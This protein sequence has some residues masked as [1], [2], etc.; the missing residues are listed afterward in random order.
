MMLTAG[1]GGMRWGAC[2][3]YGL[4]ISSSG[5]RCRMF[6]KKE[7]HTLKFLH[8]YGTISHTISNETCLQWIHL[9]FPLLSTEEDRFVVMSLS[10]FAFRKWHH[11]L[12]TLCFL[13][14]CVTTLSL[15]PSFFFCC[16]WLDWRACLAH[17]KPWPDLKAKQSVELSARVA[18]SPSRSD[19]YTAAHL[20]SWTAAG[21]PADV[22][23]E[24]ETY[25]AFSSCVCKVSEM[26]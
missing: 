15:N 11:F 2:G 17:T 13:Q 23:W 25:Y 21:G 19:G 9:K 18:L 1:P 3:S 8:S 10:W 7:P 20:L 24:P 5:G 12:S 26:L 16:V 6:L 14:A 4:S 22:G